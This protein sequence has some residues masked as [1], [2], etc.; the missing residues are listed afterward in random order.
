MA[1]YTKVGDKGET[2]VFGKRTCE[3]IKVS[4][5]SRKIRAIGAIDE[6]NSFLGIVGGLEDIQDDLFTINAILAGGKLQFSKIRTKKLERQI[7]KWEEKLPVQ[8]S[9]IYYG[10]NLQA[11]L[12]F[13]ARAI[14]RRAEVTVVAFSRQEKV[15][16]AVLVYINRLSDYLFIKAREINWQANFK[17]KAWRR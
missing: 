3:L 9:F 13:Y 2:R 11:S 7:D 5:K 17:E 4:K 12:L 16:P 8:K 6:L 1:I 10:G 14:C 15:K